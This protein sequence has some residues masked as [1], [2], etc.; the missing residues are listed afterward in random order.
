MSPGAGRSVRLLGWVVAGNAVA[1]AIAF[2]LS[3]ASRVTA[4]FAGWCG[5]N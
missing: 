1:I 3:P 4:A 5:I 2:G